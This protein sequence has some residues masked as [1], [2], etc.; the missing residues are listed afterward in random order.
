M[1]EK[2]YLEFSEFSEG[3]EMKSEKVRFN[4]VGSTIG[5]TNDCAVYTFKVMD[6][7]LEATY[8]KVMTYRQHKL[9]G[10][11]RLT[12]KKKSIQT[13]WEKTY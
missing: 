11:T 3:L 5:I 1:N 12:D 2:R 13:K 7:F 10:W 8:R 9:Y 4:E 6:Q